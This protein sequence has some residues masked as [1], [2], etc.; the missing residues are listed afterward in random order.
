MFQYKIYL[1]KMKKLFNKYIIIK[2][3]IIFIIG[4]ISR[5]LINYFGDDN[6]F[7]ENY[8]I[9]NEIFLNFQLYIFTFLNNKITLTN[10]YYLENK[11]F[12]NNVNNICLKD[13]VRRYTH[14]IIWEKYKDE[15]NTYKEFKNNWNSDKK[16]R[17]EIINDLKKELSDKHRDYLQTK[18][19][20]SWIINVFRGKNE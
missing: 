10:S 5:A 8:F 9:I 20:I 17:K 3:F 19:T 2:I 15:S 6:I 4:F 16:I 13:R 18:R 1:R 14:W 12:T 7:V 11:I